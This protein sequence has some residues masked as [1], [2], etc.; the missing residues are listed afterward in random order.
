MLLNYVHSSIICN[1]QNLEITE[2][3]IK[4]MWYVYMECYSAVKNDDLMKFVGKWMELEK[5]HS[6]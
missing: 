1:S 2:E 6:E 5:N 4:K 3:W